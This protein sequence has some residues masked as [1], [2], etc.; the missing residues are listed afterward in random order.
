MPAE[1][2]T[3]ISRIISHKNLLLKYLCV[4][5]YYP[6]FIKSFLHF[7]MHI[8]RVVC[9]LWR[10]FLHSEFL[11]IIMIIMIIMITRIIIII[12]IIIIISYISAVQMCSL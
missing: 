7:I 5:V 8:K 4:S 2:R 12:I 10:V 9:I 1:L 11:I 6:M 3:R